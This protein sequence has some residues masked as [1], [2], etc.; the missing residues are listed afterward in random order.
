MVQISKG[1]LKMVKQL[2]KIE[3]VVTPVTAEDG[4]QGW[5]EDV[6]DVNQYNLTLA[7]QFNDSRNT[8]PLNGYNTEVW[9]IEGTQ[10]DIDRFVVDNPA[11]IVKITPVEAK[12]LADAIRPG[13]TVTC[14]CCKGTG[15]KVTPPW[16]SPV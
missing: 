8:S 6:P 4:A 5:K 1:D 11:V 12:T 16:V 15:T 10:A 7:R 14:D 9:L 3:P 13:K 2:V